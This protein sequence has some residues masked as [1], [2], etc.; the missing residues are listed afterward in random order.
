MLRAEEI[1]F[2]RENTIGYPISN[3]QPCK[4]MHVSNIAQT[5]ILII[6][7]IYK[8]FIY[9]LTFNYIVLV[10]QLLRSHASR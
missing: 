7:E 1:V 10:E 4:H 2:H 3:N 9:P 6:L 5:E 8:S